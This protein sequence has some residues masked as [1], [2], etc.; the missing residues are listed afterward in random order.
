LGVRLG[1][2]IHEKGMITVLLNYDP[3]TGGELW[4][5][6]DRATD[7]GRRGRAWSGMPIDDGRERLPGDGHVAARRRT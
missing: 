4:R 2:A 7:A 6:F 1:S 5:L 3:F